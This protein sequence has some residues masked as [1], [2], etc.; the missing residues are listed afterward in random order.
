M[1]YFLDTEFNG[2]DGDLIS[3]ALV[4]D[5]GREMYTAT[6]CQEPV[7]WVAANIMPIIRCSGAYPIPCRR[8][9]FGILVA[10][11]LGGDENPL[12]I[13]DWPTILP[14]SAKS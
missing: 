7:P 8:R 9:Q 11:L 6:S 14:I 12:I 10:E 1:R 2:Q 13:A 5:D 4:A 3:L